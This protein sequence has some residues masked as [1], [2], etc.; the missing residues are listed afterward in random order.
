MVVLPVTPLR[1]GDRFLVP[2][3]PLHLTV[4]APFLTDA[5]PEAIAEVLA[6]AT[7]GQPFITATAGPEELF[8]RRHNI[9]VTL[10]QENTALNALH[11]VIVDAVRPF[12]AVPTEAAFTGTEFR[13]HIT[14]KHHGRVSAGD[15]L[16]FSQ[17]ALVDMAPRAAPAGRTVLAVSS[18]N[19]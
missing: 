1:A 4:L 3:W 15:T 6:R 16:L 12:G 10:V 18:L 2:D 11:R 5:A 19:G 13:P 8:G 7:A 9:P 17:L 14:T